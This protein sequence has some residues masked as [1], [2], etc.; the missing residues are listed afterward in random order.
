M[1]TA[2]AWPQYRTKGKLAAEAR[3]LTNVEYD[4]AYCQRHQ[5]TC[6]WPYST[7][8]RWVHAGWRQE[9]DFVPHAPAPSTPHQDAPSAPTPPSS[10][11]H[12]RICRPRP[13]H[14]PIALRSGY[15]DCVSVPFPPATPPHRTRRNECR[16]GTMQTIAAWRSLHRN[17]SLPQTYPDVRQV[18]AIHAH[19]HKTCRQ[20]WLRA[21]VRA[22]ISR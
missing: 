20:A 12:R 1:A 9:H 19:P 3:D 17:Q 11:T 18:Q 4:Q 5:D 10:P 6:P 15:Q 13:M 7:H 16:R 2:D 22:R 14:R 21:R 8:T